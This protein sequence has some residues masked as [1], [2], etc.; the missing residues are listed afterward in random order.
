[1]RGALFF[2]HA[3]PEFSRLSSTESVWH[4]LLAAMWISIRTQTLVMH[5]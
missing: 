4:R 3:L 1:M 5:S 2:C